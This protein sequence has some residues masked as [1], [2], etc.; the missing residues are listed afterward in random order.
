MFLTTEISHELWTTSW[1]LS[2]VFVRKIRNFLKYKRKLN[3]K[4]KIVGTQRS[5]N[6]F[7]LKMLHLQKQFIIAINYP[8]YQQTRHKLMDSQ[9]RDDGTILDSSI[10][11][12]IL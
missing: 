4:Q 2:K 5:L 11:S 6:S 7:I 12:T 3:F 8:R 10:V 1:F 9:V